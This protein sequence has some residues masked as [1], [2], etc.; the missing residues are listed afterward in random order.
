MPE[1]RGGKDGRGCVRST[2]PGDGENTGC[3]NEAVN[4]DSFP[5]IQAI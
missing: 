4:V 3:N 2:R 5:Y 1:G